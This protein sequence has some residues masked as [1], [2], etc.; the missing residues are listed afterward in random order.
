M[1]RFITNI[2][3]LIILCT[4]AWAAP[5][6]VSAWAEKDIDALIKLN[7]LDKRMEE[8]YQKPIT[9]ADFAY[10]AV[11]MHE[12]ITGK[13]ASVGEATFP[14]TTDPYVLKAKNIGIVNG[15]PNGNFV[16]NNYISRQEIAKLFVLT[17]QKAG[18][19]LKTEETFVFEDD[20]DIMSWAKPYVYIAYAEE[21]IKGVEKDKFAPNAYSTREQALVMLKRIIDKH[22]DLEN[23]KVEETGNKGLE[24]GAKAPEFKLELDED[25]SLSLSDYSGQAV[26]LLFVTPN[27]NICQE[28]IAI[29]AEKQE[30]YNNINFIVLNIADTERDNQLTESK[31][32]S[33][34]VKDN[35]INELYKIESVPTTVIVGGDGKLVYYGSG[36]ISGEDLDKIL[37]D[38]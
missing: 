20:S 25:K 32:L 27:F 17:L 10:L 19:E 37:K 36:K 7:I 11:L 13:K 33:I 23:V 22:A 34:F 26:V 28:Q 16:P 6:K 30:Q 29:L 31:L 1:K 5:S 14:D 18:V 12:I 8:R 24:I 15:Y 3:I 2:L 21:I 35:E 9:R 4:S 38:L